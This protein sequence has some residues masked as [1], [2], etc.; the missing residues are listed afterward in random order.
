MPKE[1]RAAFGLVNGEAYLQAAGQAPVAATI[2]NSRLDI[3]FA[4]RTFATSL[5]VVGGGAQVGVHAKGDITSK[6]ELISDL[7]GSNANVRGYLGGANAQEAAYIFRSTGTPA[8]S[9]FGATRWAR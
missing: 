4:A 2:Q 9:A 6:G 7:I 3:D 8:L 1:G 5:D